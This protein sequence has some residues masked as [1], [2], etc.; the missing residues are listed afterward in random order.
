MAH[1][2]TPIVTEW[3]D[4]DLIAVAL[5]AGARVLQGTFAVIGNDGYAVASN[6]VGAADQICLGIWDNSAENNGQA[7]DVVAL[8]SRHKQFLV[9]NSDSDPVT[10]ADIGK[11][12]YVE[13]NCTVA[14]TDGSGS[15]SIVGKLMAIDTTYQGYVWVEIN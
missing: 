5:A 8:V 3:R 11:S 2:T 12:V 15:R 10:V 1:A 4:G 13:D 7:G 6:A 9:R 14:K